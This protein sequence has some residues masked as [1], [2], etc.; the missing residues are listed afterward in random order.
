MRR[1]ETA[2]DSGWSAGDEHRGLV[3]RLEAITTDLGGRAALA[4]RAGIAPSSLQNYF[5]HSEPTRPVLIALARAAHV[6]I[7]WLVTGRGPKNADNLPEGYFGIAYYDLRPYGDRIHPLLGQPLEFRILSK[8]D[9]D[10]RLIT[11]GTLQAIQTSDGLPPHIANGDLFVVDTAVHVGPVV[12][13]G[14]FPN[15]HYDLEEAAIYA[16]AY[17]ARLRL[18]QLRWKELGTIMTVLAPR[19]KKAE[20]TVTDKTLDFQVIGRV[21]WRGGPQPA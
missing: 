14:R 5:D 4:K 1:D 3:A 8:S 2:V 12:A 6:S 7:T 9:F 11:S 10:E 20:L 17:Q 21:V 15:T 13:G 19:S 16:T 18:R